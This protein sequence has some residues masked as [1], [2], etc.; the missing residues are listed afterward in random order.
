MTATKFIGPCV[1]TG[2]FLTMGCLYAQNVSPNT[3]PTAHEEQIIAAAKAVAAPQFNGARIVGIRPGT[4]FLHSLA[5]SGTRPVT[6][7]VKKLP[8][9]LSL[10]A[11]TGIITGAL[12]RAG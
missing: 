12:K 1:A 8:D 9:D 3:N 5:V 10:D 11:K 7:S 4:P 6:F 2:L